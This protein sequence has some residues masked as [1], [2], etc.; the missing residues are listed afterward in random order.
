LTNAVEAIVLVLGS[1]GAVGMSLF[2]RSRG[3]KNWWA[4]MVSVPI[5]LY[6]AVAVAT[7]HHISGRTG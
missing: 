1:V 4:Y 3:I 6:L 5:L 2:A 7:G